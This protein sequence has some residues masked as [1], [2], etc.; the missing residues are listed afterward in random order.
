M[1]TQAHDTTQQEYEAI[2][3]GTALRAYAAAAPLSLRG[4]DRADFLHR[5]TTNDINA[6]RPGHAAVTVLTTPTARIQSVFTVLCR[7]EDLLLLPTPGESGA[8][9]AHLRGQVFFMDQVE[10]HDVAVDRWR[11]VGPSA[12]AAL[13]ALGHLAGDAADGLWWE[14]DGVLITQQEQYGVPGFEVIAPAAVGEGLVAALEAGGA[15]VLADD[16]AYHRRRIELG[17]PAPGYELTEDY[18]PLEVGLAWTCSGSKG[19]Y[20]GQ[21][22]IARQITYDKVTKSLVGLSCDDEVNAGAQVI[23]GDKSAGKVTSGTFSPPSGRHIA[24]A[25]VQRPHNAPGARVTVRHED[26]REVTAEI[27]ELPFGA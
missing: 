6:L 25:V 21:E 11:I 8:L 16:V 13:D 24:L 26:A 18:N 12:A 14:S 4:A 23:A 27:V 7:D 20:T 2:R 10:I 3:G 1:S 22:I 15:S 17:R 5:M 9:A 19:C